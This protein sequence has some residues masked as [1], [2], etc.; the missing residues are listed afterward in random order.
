MK[1]KYFI[2][3]IGLLLAMTSFT[4]CVKDV[5]NED[6]AL[7][8]LGTESYFRFYDE[9]V[10]AELDTVF[11]NYISENNRYDYLNLYNV[12]FIATK[13]EGSYD[14]SRDPIEGIEFADP[15]RLSQIASIAD[16]RLSGQNN[17]IIS[18]DMSFDTIVGTE[19]SNNDRFK[20]H[21]SVVADTLYVVG[22]VGNTGHFLMYGDADNE[23]VRG[24]ANNNGEFD[25]SSIGY[26]KYVYK[27]VIIMV[28][29]K[30]NEGVRGMLYFEYVTDV[31]ESTIGEFPIVGDIRAF[32]DPL[33]SF[34]F[35]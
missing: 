32:G 26:Q 13:M 16:V 21:E 11:N 17:C 27:S 34:N 7:V 22:E 8:F 18:M 29:E 24:Y 2:L 33:S 5:E 19:N 14:F 12:S 28:G 35:N 6:E 9:V 31:I 3:L 23:H 25:M 15:L 20:I 10:P 30:T 4:S 1:N